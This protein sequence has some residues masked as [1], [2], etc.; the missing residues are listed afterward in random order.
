MLI[1][2]CILFLFSEL[3]LPKG[4]AIVCFLSSAPRMQSFL[5]TT[6][7]LTKVYYDVH[8]PKQISTF[9][10]NCYNIY[11]VYKCLPL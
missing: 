5:G 11:N 4:T 6:T 9:M 10:N 7:W 8:S 3:K 2:I 1:F